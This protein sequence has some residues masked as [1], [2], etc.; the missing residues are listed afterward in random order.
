[1]ENKELNKLNISDLDDDY[2]TIYI[3]NRSDFFVIKDITFRSDDDDYALT[4]DMFCQDKSKE[5]RN[6]VYM[7]FNKDQ[8]QFLID[9]LSKN[10]L[11][12]KK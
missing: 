2:F 12:T 3:K 5:N 11:S 6:R 1:M 10:C 7:E 8:V 9:W 4:I